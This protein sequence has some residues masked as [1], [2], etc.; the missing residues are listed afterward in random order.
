MLF[1]KMLYMIEDS[2]RKKE[3]DITR[4]TNEHLIQNKEGLMY[5]KIIQ[6]LKTLYPIKLKGTY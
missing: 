4:K 6:N 3:K 2:M 5:D 1:E